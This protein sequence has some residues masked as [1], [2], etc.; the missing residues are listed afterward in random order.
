M[1]FLSTNFQFTHYPKD[2][3]LTSGIQLDWEIQQ[4][5]VNPCCER[6]LKRLKNIQNCSSS[7]QFMW[8]L[9][10]LEDISFLC[11]LQIKNLGQEGVTELAIRLQNWV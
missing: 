5:S 1:L 7:R 8:C 11:I 10:L 3:S 2:G 9:S 6:L 4:C